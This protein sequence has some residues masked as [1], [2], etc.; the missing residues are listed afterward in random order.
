MHKLSHPHILRF[1]D[2]YETRH[3]LWLIL[4]YCTGGDLETILKQDGHLPETSIRIFGVD[5][6]AGM[7]YLHSLGFIHCDLRPRNFLID[8]YGILKISDFKRTIKIPTVPLD[9]KPIAERGLAPYM[10]P[11][12]FTSEGA[13]SFQS[14]FWALGCVLFELRRGFL[15]FGDQEQ[16]LEMLM[17]N[18]QN[19]DAIT[20]PV[21]PPSLITPG[22]SGKQATGP[23]LTSISN[24]FADLL[25]GLLE[26]SLL[27][28]SSWEQLCHH[29]FWRPANPPPPQQLPPQPV[30]DN[31]I[32]EM[33]R[34]RSELLQKQIY[35][36]MGV[37]NTSIDLTAVN[38]REG[39]KSSSPL[40][41]QV[42]VTGGTPLAAGSKVARRQW[43]E[44]NAPPP[45]SSQAKPASAS[46]TSNPRSDSKSLA[47]PRGNLSE[48]KRRLFEED[49]SP[50][51]NTPQPFDSNQLPLPNPEFFNAASATAV[52]SAA[53]ANRHTKSAVTDTPFAATAANAGDTGLNLEHGR[54]TGIP[55]SSAES[56]RAVVSARGPDTSSSDLLWDLSPESIL[57]HS[58]DSQVK[59]IVGNRAIE[60]ADDPEFSDK[61]VSFT[62]FKLDRLTQ[63]SQDE[64]EAHL[65]Q[66]YKLLYKSATAAQATVA[67]ATVVGA[68]TERVTILTY[69]SSIVAC[70]EVANVILNTH[71]L[72]LLLKLLK[73][74][75]NYQATQ[76]LRNQ[77]PSHNAANAATSLAQQSRFLCAH[78]LA[79]MLRF[80]TYIQ[81][82]A[83]RSRDDHIVGTLIQVLKD[84]QG[85]STARTMSMDAKMRR[86]AVAALG[87]MIFYISAQDEDAPTNTNNNNEAVADKWTLAPSTVEFLIKS[88]KDEP[89]EIVKHYLAKTIENVQAQGGFSFRKRFVSYELCL[90]L[91]EL[92]QNNTR[93]ES[94]Q[95]TCA[96]ALFH[97]LYFA[98]SFHQDPLSAMTAGREN[99]TSA[100]KSGSA[101]GSNVRTRPTQ[102]QPA[103]ATLD[104][105]ASP[106]LVNSSRFFTKILEKTNLGSLVETLQD[107]TPKLQQAFLNII[108]LIF[109]APIGNH[110]GVSMAAIDPQVVS[111][112]QGE[113]GAMEQELQHS[114]FP[115]F[116]MTVTVPD[117]PTGKL[118]PAQIQAIHGQL[119]PLRSYFLR[120]QTVLM[121]ALFRLMD[122]GGATPLRAKA[123][124][125]VQC[126]CSQMPILLVQ[127]PEKKFSTALVRILDPYLSALEAQI[128]QQQLHLVAEHTHQAN[129]MTRQLQVN[130]VKKLSSPTYLMKAVTSMLVFLRK[131]LVYHVAS[132]ALYIEEIAQASTFSIATG[133]EDED[134]HS[135]KRNT[136][137]PTSPAN[138]NKIGAGR[139]PASPSA[140]VGSR[141]SFTVSQFVHVTKMIRAVAALFSAPS[142]VRIFMPNTVEFVR[143]LARMIQ[144]LPAARARIVALPRSSVE[145]M[146]E[147]FETAEQT[148]LLCLEFAAQVDI[149]SYYWS[150]VSLNLS[151]QHISNTI[152]ND[153]SL[154]QKLSQWSLLITMTLQRLIPAASRLLTHP[155]A[156]IRIMITGTFRRLLPNYVRAFFVAQHPDMHLHD[157]QQQ[158]AVGHHKRPATKSVLATIQ[159][160]LTTM[161]STYLLAAPSQMND[162]APIPQYALRTY[163][164]L[165][166]IHSML[167][168]EILSTAWKQGNVVSVLIQVL[169]VQSTSSTSSS[170]AAAAGGGRTSDAD[171][172][173]HAPSQAQSGLDPLLITILRQLWDVG[174]GHELQLLQQDLAG[175][176]TVTVI[177]TVYAQISY[178][179]CVTSSTYKENDGDEDS[180][181]RNHNNS[182]IAF[183]TLLPMLDM[184]YVMLHYVLKISA[185]S[186]A[187]QTSPNRPSSSSTSANT[188]DVQ[189]QYRRLV[190]S[191][192][193]TSPA[194]LLLIAY[195]E[196]T[197]LHGTN[198]EFSDDTRAG[199]S[200]RRYPTRP[201][202]AAGTTNNPSA[203]AA[204]A[205]TGGALH[206]I[207]DLS[208]K[209]LGMLF[210]LFPDIVASQ[211]LSRQ[212]VLLDQQQQ[213]SS[214][215]PRQARRSYGVAGFV[216]P[217]ALSPRLILTS[218]LYNPQVDLRV[219][220]KILKIFYGA[221][222]VAM[223]MGHVAKVKEWLS[224]EPMY[225]ALQFGSR[226][227]RMTPYLPPATQQPQDAHHA[228]HQQPTAQEIVSNIQRLSVQMMELA[229]S[230]PTNN[231]S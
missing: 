40:K 9:Q 65:T 129:A 90:V 222:K 146:F 145:S 229:T 124:L 56:G 166:Q 38:N 183:E 186:A 78:N 72:T 218:A 8:E 82:P 5:M 208:T 11:E 211:L 225:P 158:A 16:R 73:T 23:S 185:Q 117:P 59:P 135:A 121:P 80:A 109:L 180:N 196:Y 209:C 27:N 213:Q 152:N 58:S 227:T 154:R 62:T 66:L 157:P 57:S 18:I 171:S 219:A 79:M 39:F 77:S 165:F 119:S 13:N 139:Q 202:T 138:K 159:T 10:A 41:P 99:V 193:A 181:V 103:A 156:D 95:S 2:W 111:A 34:M 112:M 210:D 108:L 228:H 21:I 230:L 101:G 204:A 131:S 169:Q 195:A 179:F 217:D 163:H 215:S 203:V 60:D 200:S 177:A 118:D 94:L 61:N 75:T 141:L 102:A 133:G 207:L 226:W 149:P 97:I 55:P 197:L 142:L 162:V 64:L 22:K 25:R 104:P 91:L 43:D 33:E 164:D 98:L 12:L 167:T 89:D 20:S 123:M 83:I 125:L 81:A 110:S 26:K 128:Q 136:F 170:S 190:T 42:A 127:L 205:S 192:R 187:Q 93:N 155:D 114:S 150:C 173:S 178:P 106:S 52:G 36:E 76:P 147:A 92:A 86:K 28:R 1:Y 88:L 45:P 134:M 24:P 153:L 84:T 30:I 7:K 100:G 31:L 4:E 199:S 54:N 116:G 63:M 168:R 51:N 69:L 160:I 198:S 132:L 206:H 220:L 143:W 144:A 194:L 47:E 212:S 85:S 15:P 201:T 96:M 184:L 113:A 223:N 32:S 151:S 71:F 48:A 49:S 122:H 174:Q 74:T 44:E 67:N 50:R 231:N 172:V 182:D 148:A 214:Q 115:S 17:D 6:V 35:S 19:I 70:A 37:Y 3:N 46:T 216:D 189:Q 126:L 176:L 224:Q 105:F 107:G 87:E 188:A 68:L 175:A 191:L 14:D 130:N 140:A 221:S 120:A 53:V 29:P 137:S 161:L